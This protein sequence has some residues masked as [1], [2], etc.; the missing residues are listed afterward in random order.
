MYMD[1]LCRYNTPSTLGSLPGNAAQAQGADPLAA[2][3]ERR[4]AKAIKV[5]MQC[6]YSYYICVWHV[7]YHPC[8][9]YIF[10][11]IMHIIY[12]TD[13]TPSTL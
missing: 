4:R 12:T 3:I 13:P 8:T 9:T 5:F 1:I 7:Y 6:F 2:L 11:C 10:Y